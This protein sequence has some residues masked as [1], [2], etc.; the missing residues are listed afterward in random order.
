MTV[1][2]FVRNNRESIDSFIASAIGSPIPRGL[3]NDSQREL[4][5]SND[6]GLYNWYQSERGG[7][8]VAH[9]RKGRVVRKETTIPRRTGGGVTLVTYSKAPGRGAMN[10]RDRKKK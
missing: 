6:E 7:N 4:W 3:K 1:R 2:Q 10:P 5:V 8:Q 9:R